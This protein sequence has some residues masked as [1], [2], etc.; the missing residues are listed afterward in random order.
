M[1]DALRTIDP[2]DVPPPP[3]ARY[4]GMA[5]PPDALDIGSGHAISFSHYQGEVAGIQDWHVKPD[6]AWCVGWVAFRGSAWERGFQNLTAWDV[7]QREPLT[8]TPS[9]LCRT[10]G[11]HGFIRDGKWVRA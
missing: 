1:P 3:E 2:K 8:L 7:V 5:P 4:A 6:G 11:D 9:L 10:C